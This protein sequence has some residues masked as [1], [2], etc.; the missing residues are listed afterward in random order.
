MYE[1]EIDDVVIDFFV[2]DCLIQGK[3]ELLFFGSRF[4]C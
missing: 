4:L 1:K 2:V 3:K